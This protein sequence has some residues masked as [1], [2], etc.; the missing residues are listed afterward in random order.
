AWDR[1]GNLFMADHGNRRIRKIAPN[2]VISTI[3][4]TGIDGYSGDGGPATSAQIGYVEK[5]AVDNADNLYFVDSAYGGPNHRVRKI[6]ADGKIST[7]AGTGVA[8]FSGDGGRANAAHVCAP[9]AFSPDAPGKTSISD[10][11]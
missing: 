10:D 1:N 6:S 3:A 7:V 8:G 5:V 4:G 11:P 2:G 9:P